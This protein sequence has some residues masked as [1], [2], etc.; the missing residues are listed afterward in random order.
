[1]VGLWA[2]FRGFEPAEL[3]AVAR[4]LRPGGRLL[5]VLDYGRDDV[6][7]LRGDLSEYGLLSRRD[8]PY[9]RGGFRVRVVHCFWTFETQEEIT[10]F[11]DDA[12]GP[13]GLDVAGGLKRPRLSYNVAVYHRAF[14]AGGPCVSAA[15]KSRRRR[16]RITPGIVFL[17]VAMVGADRPSRATW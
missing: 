14:G 17:A 9:L 16:R 11:L 2:A 12:F 10:T 7:R 15:V 6:S 3:A 13:I 5:V 4:V 1:M 8:G